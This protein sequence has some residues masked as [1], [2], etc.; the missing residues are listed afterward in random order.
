M[1]RR[2]L[3]AFTFGVFVGLM[4]SFIGILLFLYFT[5]SGAPE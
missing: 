3:N 5:S 1:N 2:E 4:M